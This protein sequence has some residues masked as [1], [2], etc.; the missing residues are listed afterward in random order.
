MPQ[1][2][3]DD[4]SRNADFVLWHHRFRLKKAGG[5]GACLGSSMELTNSLLNDYT[6]PHFYN[7]TILQYEQFVAPVRP[8][9]TPGKVDFFREAR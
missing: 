8:R 7:R 2:D 1:F 9:E 3:L 6:T 4:H 5:G